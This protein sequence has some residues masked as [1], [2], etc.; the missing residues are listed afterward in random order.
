M[1]QVGEIHP[2]LCIVHVK[3]L[4]HLL[5]MII[6]W[7]PGEARTLQTPLALHKYFIKSALL[8]LS[9]NLKG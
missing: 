1:F 6:C 5:P 8:E 2:K 7:F 4:L 9:L 3:S